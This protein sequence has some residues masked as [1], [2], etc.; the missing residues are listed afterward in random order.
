MNQY[1]GAVGYPAVPEMALLEIRGP[2]Q[3]KIMVPACRIVKRVRQ[4]P[5]LNVCSRVGGAGLTADIFLA[6]TG[7][8]NFAPVEAGVWLVSSR[9]GFGES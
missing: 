7:S 2:E 9:T 4:N 5:W 3:V 8:D 1:L 6:P